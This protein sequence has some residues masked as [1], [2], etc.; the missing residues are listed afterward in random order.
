MNVPKDYFF[1]HYLGRRES[2]TLNTFERNIA[3][4]LADP[5]D[6]L[7]ERLYAFDTWQFT[8]YDKYMAPCFD[9]EAKARLHEEQFPKDLEAAFKAGVRMA[10]A[11]PKNA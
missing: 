2:D 6:V 9:K 1:E 11:L 5:T 10:Q 8:D 4:I 3:H 7:S